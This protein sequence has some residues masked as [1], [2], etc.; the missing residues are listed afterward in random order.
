[1]SYLIQVGM[2]VI[3]GCFIFGCDS[4]LFSN[5][6]FLKNKS[7]SE[8]T[9]ASGHIEDEISNEQDSLFVELKHKSEHS[10]FSR[11]YEIITTPVSK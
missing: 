7:I 8:E 10:I 5:T 9:V 2:L 4:I 3:I 6:L 1:M 11:F